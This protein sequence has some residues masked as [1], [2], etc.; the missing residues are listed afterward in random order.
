[1]NCGQRISAIFIVAASA[2]AGEGWKA[3]AAS[4]K[5]TPEGPLWTSG[6]SKR[7]QPA[8]GTSQ[9]LFAK[10]LALEAP[11]G[12]LAVLVTLDVVGCESLRSR[13]CCRAAEHPDLHCRRPGLGRLADKAGDLCA[14]LDAEFSHPAEN[15]AR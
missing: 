14:R 1:L 4:A 2:H 5:I 7:T 12:R 6:F 8:E 11:G 9:E 10:A 3:G 13:C 15:Q